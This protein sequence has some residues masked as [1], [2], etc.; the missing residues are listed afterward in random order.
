MH[1]KKKNKKFFVIISLL[2]P[3][4]IFA[5]LFLIKPKRNSTVPNNNSSK[6]ILNDTIKKTKLKD[7][8]DLVQKERKTS[9]SSVSDG[10]NT[11]NT[12]VD[13]KKDE[14][15]QKNSLPVLTPIN[16][17]V[18]KKDTSSSKKINQKSP[19]KN[20]LSESANKSTAIPKKGVKQNEV[21]IKLTPIQ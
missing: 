17:D 12:K 7:S 9:K 13:S 16:D 5:L 10:Y 2:L 1:Q 15:N 14:L 4:I 19:T 8:I 6:S 20:N 21:E 18:E 3:V 11:N